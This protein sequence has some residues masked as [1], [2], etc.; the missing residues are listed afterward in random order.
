M[1]LFPDKCTYLSVIYSLVFVVCAGLVVD[2][3]E[4]AQKLKGCTIINNY[5]DI[6][7]RGGEYI[8]TY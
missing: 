7:I 6:Q 5:L 8:Y 2:S 1:A 4:N 3:I